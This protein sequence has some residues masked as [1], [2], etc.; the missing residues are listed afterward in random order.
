MSLDF[1]SHWVTSDSYLTP[2]NL[3]SLI[4]KMKTIVAPN[5]GL[6]LK[7]NN[8]CTIFTMCFLVTCPVNVNKMN[9]S[10]FHYRV[11]ERTIKKSRLLHLLV[12]KSMLNL[13]LLLSIHLTL[14]TRPT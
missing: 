4:S 6:L 1:L 10:Y 5:S 8:T 12:P 7:L 11:S 3:N 14:I 9:N 13:V 2:Q